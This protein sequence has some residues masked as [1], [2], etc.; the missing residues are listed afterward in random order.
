MV[1]NHVNCGVLLL[2]VRYY[3]Q[4]LFFFSV[5]L[6]IFNLV[7]GGL[8]IVGI[9]NAKS[10]RKCRRMNKKKKKHTVTSQHEITEKSLLQKEP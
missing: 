4:I 2:I 9:Y 3:I 5:S 6:F 1:E 10:P 7:D 8:Y